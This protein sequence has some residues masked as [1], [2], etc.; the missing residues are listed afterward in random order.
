MFFKVQSLFE[1]FLVIIAA[2]ILFISAF[3]HQLVLKLFAVFFWA[4]TCIRDKEALILA[5]VASC[6]TFFFLFYCLQSAAGILVV[7]LWLSTIT[8]LCFLLLHCISIRD[9]SLKY[10]FGASSMLHWQFALWIWSVQ[11][12]CWVVFHEYMQVWQLSVPHLILTGCI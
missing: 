8:L 9:R 2:S 3:M 11:G 1:M 12:I 5:W 10:A 4:T 6:V 7:G